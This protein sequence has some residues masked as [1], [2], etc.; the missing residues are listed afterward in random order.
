MLR[1]LRTGATASLP[2]IYVNY[3][4]N[5]TFNMTD[6]MG[7]TLTSIP[8]GAYQILVTSPAP[9]AA[10]DLAGINDMTACKGSANFQLTGPGVT[11]TT[12]LDDG[13]S[14]SAFIY[15]TFLPSST[16]TAVDMTQPSVAHFTFTTTATG[17]ASAPVTTPASTTTAAAHPASIIVSAPPKTK[18]TLTATVG[19]G[20]GVKL[21]AGGKVVTSLHTGRYTFVVTDHSPRRRIR[22]RARCEEVALDHDARVRR[23]AH[24]RP[25]A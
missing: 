8:P 10:V 4:M 1:A 11:L 22:A 19:L 3:T 24:A 20:G 18:G 15:G 5:C 23:P 14:E 2:T 17:V 16:Y 25:F 21:T 12:T 6:A 7:K 9:F 13:D